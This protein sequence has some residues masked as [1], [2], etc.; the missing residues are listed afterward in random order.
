[1]EHM[2]AFEGDICNDE[3]HLCTGHVTV[4]TTLYKTDTWLWPG[5]TEITASDKFYLEYSAQMEHVKAY[6]GSHM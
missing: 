3:Q 1:M 4:S 2:I 5:M 6:E